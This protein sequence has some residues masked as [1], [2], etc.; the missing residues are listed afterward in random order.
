[1]LQRDLQPARGGSLGRWAC[2][3]GERAENE[4]ENENENEEKYF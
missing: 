1:M 3:L 2:S 4:N